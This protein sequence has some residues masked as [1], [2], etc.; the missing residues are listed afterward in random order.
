MHN[1]SNSK[2]L[3]VWQWGEVQFL[4]FSDIGTEDKV[5]EKEAFLELTGG[6]SEEFDF[7]IERKEFEL[8]YFFSRD[9]CTD[10]LF[11]L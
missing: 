2:Y 7:E 8:V 5:A 11:S 3:V 9:L 6:A 10:P 1:E 4:M